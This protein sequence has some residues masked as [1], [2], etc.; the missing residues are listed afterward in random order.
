MPQDKKLTRE[1]LDHLWKNDPD[2]ITMETR[3]KK[4]ALI[5]DL[6]LGDGKKADN[7]AHNKKIL[8]TALDKYFAENYELILLGDIEEFWQFDLDTI[9]DTYNNSIYRILRK[10]GENRVHRIF[11]NHDKEWGSLEDPSRNHQIQRSNAAEAIKMK[12]VNG[13]T[14][15]FLVH[16]HQGSIESDKTCW[17]SKFFVKISTPF[18]A[19]AH[20]LGLIKDPSATKS[21]VMKDYEKIVYGWAKNEK[22]I[23]ICGHSHRAIFASRTYTDYIKKEISRLQKEITSNPDDRPLIKKNIKMIEKLSREK[24]DEKRKNRDL[25]FDRSGI[26]TPCYF[27]TGC[28]LYDS[29]VTAVE[30]EDDEIR[31]VKWEKGGVK[32]PAFDYNKGSLSQYVGML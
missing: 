27:N 15:I 31:L 3:G 14:R 8:E 1:R 21:Q 17:F 32:N 6:H 7:F 20:T 11:G 25:Y 2:V 26:K 28:G 4:Y 18:E 22:V 10:F 12:D 16:G 29:G 9:T 13:N 30:I 19:L 23:I 5:S 24:S